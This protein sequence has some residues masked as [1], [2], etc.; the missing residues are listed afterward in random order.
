[1]E[2]NDAEKSKLQWLKATDLLEFAGRFSAEILRFRTVAEYMLGKGLDG[3]FVN[4]GCK[5]VID[6]ASPTSFKVF[7][8]KVEDEWDQ[9]QLPGCGGR[10]RSGAWKSIR[11][12]GFQLCIRFGRW[13]PKNSLDRCGSS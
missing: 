10:R 6:G 12:S 11:K 8:G 4:Y 1:M 13:Y 7:A 9:A 5:S 3:P 2:T